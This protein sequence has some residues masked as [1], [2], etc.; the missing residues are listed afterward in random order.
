MNLLARHGMRTRG[1]S[2]LFLTA[3][4]LFGLTATGVAQ[5]S[6]IN[7]DALA[8]ETQKTSGKAG[9]ITLVW[10]IP[11]EYWRLMFTQNPTVT[12]HQGE[13]LINIFRPYTIVVVVDGKVGPLGG[14][15][16]E[17]RAD[18]AQSIELTDSQGTRYPPLDEET[19]AG[20][21]KLF[22]S[23]MK[24]VLATALGPMGQ[25]LHFFLFTAR[26][27]KGL[28]IADAKKD[29]KLS[30]KLGDREF[31]WRLPLSSLLP[32]KVCPAC[33]EKLNGAYQYC[34]WDGAKLPAAK[35]RPQQ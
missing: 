20:D 14:V 35:E 19:L 5:D 1:C 29:G 27:S 26:D 11:E 24:P 25:H 30:V 31:G 9:E 23:L 22:L 10:W 4:L 17:S 28:P 7:L 13:V 15:T 18:I 12:G 33:G 2:C 16:Y 3:L 34:P 8:Q 32:T 6:E 21:T